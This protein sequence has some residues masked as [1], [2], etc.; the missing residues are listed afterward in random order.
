MRLEIRRLQRRLQLY[1][2][3]YIENV[4]RRG[5]SC[6][7]S[8]R[9]KFSKAYSSKSKYTSVVKSKNVIY[10]HILLRGY[11]E[12]KAIGYLL[13]EKSDLFNFG[14]HLTIIL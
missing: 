4:R 8:S 5:M 12:V 6:K 1:E 3:D 14:I 10:F 2:V 11:I 9:D 13:P 7:F